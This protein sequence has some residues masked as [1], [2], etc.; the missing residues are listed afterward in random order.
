MESYS[1][2]YCDLLSSLSI[3]QDVFT[4]KHM[5]ESSSFVKLSSFPLYGC[6]TFCLSIHPFVKPFV[7]IGRCLQG[8]LLTCCHH[9]DILSPFPE[10]NDTHIKKEKGEIIAYSGFPTK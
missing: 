4:L 9:V 2:F 5:S 1:I 10:I 6:I 3:T 7:Y 8:C